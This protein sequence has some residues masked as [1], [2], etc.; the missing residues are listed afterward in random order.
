MAAQYSRQPSRQA[1]VEVDAYA[2]LAW[3]SGGLCTPLGAIS[4]PNMKK[5]R[6]GADVQRKKLHM[7]A[8]RLG[9]QA[10]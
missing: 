10:S 7:L 5:A 1:I 6:P 3:S 9:R 8:A 2:A 4:M